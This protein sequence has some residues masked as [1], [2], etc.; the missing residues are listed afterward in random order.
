[1]RASQFI[2][3]IPIISSMIQAFV[4][5]TVAIIGRNTF[6]KW[7]EQKISERKI[8]QSERILTASYKVRRSLSDVR[9][10]FISAHELNIA[11]KNLLDSGEINDSIDLSMRKKYINIQFYYNR[12]NA[13]KQD[14]VDLYDC[15][16]FARALFG[17]ELEKSIETLNHQV[18]V[19]KVAADSTLQFD[20]T[21][22]SDFIKSTY[23][24]LC[25]GYTG[26]KI[27]EVDAEIENQIQNIEKVCI[28]NLRI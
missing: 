14:F 27:N 16:P 10:P 4:L 9:A 25:R 26:G 2:D 17:E 7:R 8:E 1:M 11:E 19:V 12:I 18:Q 20:W 24:E 13:C 5:L 6:Q 21:N 15:I 23:R 3:M 28:P 22:D